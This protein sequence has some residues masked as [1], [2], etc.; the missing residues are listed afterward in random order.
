MKW[1]EKFNN[2]NDEKMA[3]K[4]DQIIQKMVDGRIG[5]FYERVCLLD[6]PYVKEDSLTVGKYLDQAGKAMGGKIT[7]YAPYEL[8]D[9]EYPRG[10]VVWYVDEDGKRE[11][12]ETSYDPVNKQ[13][14][15][16]TDHLS[17]YMIDYNENI[18]NPF[19]DISEESEK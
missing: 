11:R 14:S 10:I 1:L 2:K 9:G 5:K 19:A 6:Q 12:C 13:V 15:W 4:P 17:L 3:N 18:N 16:K 8:Q 7:V